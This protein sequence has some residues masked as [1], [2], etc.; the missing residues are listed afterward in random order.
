MVQPTQPQDDSG[1]QGAKNAC[2]ERIEW[3]R[4]ALDSSV[5]Q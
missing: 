1:S 2:F 4:K 5:T 3:S